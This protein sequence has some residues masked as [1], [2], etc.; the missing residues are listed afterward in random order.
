MVYMVANPLI[1]WKTFTVR[2]CGGLNIDL[3]TTTDSGDNLLKYTVQIG[4]QNGERSKILDSD[5]KKGITRERA[6]M[7]KGLSLYIVDRSFSIRAYNVYRL[8][9]LLYLILYDALL[10]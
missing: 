2:S 4:V 1:D 6:R 9:L 5:G 8:L 10:I 3:F 7:H